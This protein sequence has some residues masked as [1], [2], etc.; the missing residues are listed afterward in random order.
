MRH[1]L[2]KTVTILA[3]I[4]LTFLFFWSVFKLFFFTHTALLLPQI[5]LLK[6]FKYLL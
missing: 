1:H 6:I 3:I 2:T 5:L 4:L